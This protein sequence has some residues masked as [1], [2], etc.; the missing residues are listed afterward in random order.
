MDAFGDNFVNEPE[1]DPAAEF[2]AREQDQLAGLEED[3]TPMAV[4]LAAAAAAGGQSDDDLSGKFGNLKVGPGG[5]AEGSFEMV[6]TIGQP[7]EGQ[8][9]PAEP[10]V[11]APVKEEPEKIKKWREEQKARLEEKDAE[12]EKK[13]EEWREAAKKELEEWYKHHAEAINKTKTTNRESAKNAEKQFVAEADEVEPGTE[14]ERI[15]KLCEFNPKS[16]RTSKDV[17]RMRSIIL[18]LKQTPPTP[19]NA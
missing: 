16:S 7:A 1:V 4:T 2:L 8:A 3:I 18:Q 6:D 19:I 17:S 15:A 12:E 14:W 13:R 10:A 9:A 11:P 5:D